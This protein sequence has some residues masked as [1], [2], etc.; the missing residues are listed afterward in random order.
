MID[1]FACC[2]LERIRVVLV[3]RAQIRR[4]GFHEQTRL[5]AA[6]RKS[7]AALLF[8]RPGMTARRR[9]TR[10]APENAHHLRRTAVGVDEETSRRHCGLAQDVPERPPSLDAVD[11]HRQIAL[12]SQ[13]QLLRKNRRLIREI[14]P[15]DP[16]VEAN[17]TDAGLRVRIELAPQFL[18]PVRRALGDKPRM[19]AER[20]PDARIL[21]MQA[22]R[23]FPSP[24]P[25]CR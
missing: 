3:R 20:R 11:R 7:R 15:L 5:R 25:A 24:L 23:R 12:C 19:Q 14:V 6:P 10:R 1:H 8:A 2:V 21:R 18:L 16:A 22:R 4:I 9:R 17:L 13:R